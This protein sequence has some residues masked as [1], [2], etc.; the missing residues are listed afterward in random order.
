M[1]PPPA[2]SEI[3]NIEEL[4]LTGLRL[5]QIHNP[6]LDPYAY[7]E[8][9]LKRDPGDCR[10]NTILGI[11]Y[12][13]RGM[14]T[15]GRGALEEAVE[16]ISAEYTRPGNAEAYYYLGLALKAQGKFDEA[17]DAL[18][19]A[20]WDYAFHSAAYYQLA[21]FSCRK[22]D[23]A[24]ALEQIDQ[25]LSTNTLNAKAL[26]I[27][28]VVMRNLGKLEQA[29]QIASACYRRRPARLPGNE[30]IVSCRIRAETQR[31]RAEKLMTKMRGEVE[32]Y[33]ELAVDYGNC[34]LWDEAIEV[35]DRA[36]VKKMT[37]AGKYP[38][39]YYYL[40]YFYQQKGNNA[41]AS[42]YSCFSRKNAERLLFP[43]SSGV[44][45]CS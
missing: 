18:Y 14:F 16:R 32:S 6:R 45:R 26:N 27:K 21:E 39:V 3:E 37:F 42:K 24:A 5:E 41:K 11:N 28:A 15:E 13:T 25:S 44:Y 36:T 23:F 2:P 8:E 43:I 40:G 31:L 7:Y 22:G 12:S 4:Y 29:K 19:R 38:M 17:Y 20:T 35:L 30:R 33:L 34:G 10:T 9:A 1:K